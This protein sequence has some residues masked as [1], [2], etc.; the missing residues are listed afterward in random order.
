MMYCAAVFFLIALV[1]GVAGFA[2]IAGESSGIA[3][4]LF[5][6]FIMALGISIF[7]DMVRRPHT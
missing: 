5:F 1:T 3:Q 4:I 7:M 6:I 2:G